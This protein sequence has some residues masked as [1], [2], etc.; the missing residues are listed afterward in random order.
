MKINRRGSSAHHG[1]FDITFPNP[2]IAWSATTSE[3]TISQVGVKN[4]NGPASHNYTVH[5]SAAELGLILQ[6]LAEAALASPKQLEPLLASSCKPLL[7][8]LSVVSGVR[9]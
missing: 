3:I 9:S 4:F 8:L 6:T 7:Q 1:T 5:V 2:K